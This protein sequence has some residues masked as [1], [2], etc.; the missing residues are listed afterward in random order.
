MNTRLYN[1]SDPKGFADQLDHLEELAYWVGFRAG[2]CTGIII[3][4]A[5]IIGLKK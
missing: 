4:A 5:V 1:I 2:V 3:G